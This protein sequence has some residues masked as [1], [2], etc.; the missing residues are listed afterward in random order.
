MAYS[1]PQ[2]ITIGS[3]PG[4]VSLPRTGSGVGL[5][6]FQSND[7]TVKLTVSNAYGK[8]TRRVARV[9]F[10]KIA[11]DPLISTNSIKYTTSAYLVLDQPATGFSTAEMVAITTGLATW[12]TA[13]SGANITKLVGGE[14]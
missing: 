9:D 8:R 2:S 1:D 10:S 5:G 4:T 11:P 6:T 12:L 3:T 7:T 13:S 14:N